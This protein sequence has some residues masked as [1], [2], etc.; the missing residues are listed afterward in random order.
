MMVKASEVIERDRPD[1]R[2]C[3]EDE[4][5]GRRVVGRQLCWEYRARSN[6]YKQYTRTTLFTEKLR[7]Y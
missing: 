4:Q 7:R 5:T 3:R 2:R 6:T 1:Q